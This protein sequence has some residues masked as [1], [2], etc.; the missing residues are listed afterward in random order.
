MLVSTIAVSMLHTWRVMGVEPRGVQG[1]SGQGIYLDFQTRERERMKEKGIGKVFIFY[2]EKDWSWTSVR[3][4]DIPFYENL[5][6]AQRKK[7]RRTSQESC[8]G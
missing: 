7:K 6:N 5:F 3:E 1:T 8:T 4:S 2:F